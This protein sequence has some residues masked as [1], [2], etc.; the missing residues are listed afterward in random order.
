[1]TNRNN[2][3]KP[4][5]E[6]DSLYN[7]DCEIL[8]SNR[9]RSNVKYS[10]K[11]SLNSFSNN[12]LST[13]KSFSTLKRNESYDPCN[14]LK[15]DSNLTFKP[16][17]N[18]NSIFMSLRSRLSKLMQIEFESNSITHNLNPNNYQK[19]DSLNTNNYTE[20]CSN[21]YRNTEDCFNN[22]QNFDENKYKSK[23]NRKNKFKVNYLSKTE[24]SLTSKSKSRVRSVD[25][26]NTITNRLYNYA[27]KYHF[28]KKRMAEDYYNTTCPFTP[29]LI[30]DVYK[31]HN[32]KPSMTNFFFRLQNWVD[33]RNLKYETDYENTFY[34]DKTG[35]RL[36]F[37]KINKNSGYAMRRSVNY[38]QILI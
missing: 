1:L 33:K 4:N 29:E 5:L 37:P 16:R 38:Y 19:K 14:K 6:L 34:D 8:K 13:R 17:L 25:E 27:A 32:I 35:E 30:N 26:I 11:K 18:S 28:N 22:T 24:N 3:K 31:V 7:T 10:N 15:K 9:F 2:N 12:L 23:N 20:T 36:F 21:F